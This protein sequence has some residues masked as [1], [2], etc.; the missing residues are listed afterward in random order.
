VRRIIEKDGAK[1]TWQ[2]LKEH[3]VKFIPLFALSIPGK[4]AAGVILSG[5]FVYFKFY[6][7][8]EPV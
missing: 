1:E 2:F 3:K 8:K 5:V 7:K 6:K 4:I